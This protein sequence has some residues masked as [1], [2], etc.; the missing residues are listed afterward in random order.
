LPQDTGW[1]YDLLVKAGVDPSTAKTVVD[2][3]VRPLAVIIIV[4]LAILVAQLGAKAIR[5]HLGRVIERAA[6]RSPT[7]RSTSRATA[8]ALLVAN[9]WRVFVYVVAVLIVLSTLGINLTPILAS[10]TVIAAVVAFGA[11]QLVRDNLSGFLLTLEDQ[12]G[13]GDT[14]TVDGTTG[15]VEDL[16]LRV[17][18][19]RGD[20]GTVWYVPNGD[21][22]KLGNVSRGWAKAIVELVFSPTAAADLDRVHTVV[23]T[24]AAGVA[25]SPRFSTSC[26]EPPEVLGI[27]A[28]DGTTCTIRVGLRTSTTNRAPL[29]RKL[30]EACVSA[31]M[32]DGLWPVGA[33]DSS[34]TTAASD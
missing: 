22:R 5:H 16:R 1:F 31:L 29:E 24:A 15:V 7:P 20:D 9:L 21:I 26:T 11:Q 8:T 28:S 10:A 17:T 6:D 33:A 27:V 14:I 32:G 3:V 25:A 4:V 2:F 23:A 13:I 12:Y 18:R 19:L 30:R 34:P